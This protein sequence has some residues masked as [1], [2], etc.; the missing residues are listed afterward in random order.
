MFAKLVYRGLP[1]SVLMTVTAFLQY[2]AI[3]AFA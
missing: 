2:F 1:A 3:R